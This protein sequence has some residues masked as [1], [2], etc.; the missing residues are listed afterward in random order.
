[1]PPLNR[2]EPPASLLM[3]NPLRVLVTR[4]YPPDLTSKLASEFQVIA[5]P[6]E[7]QSFNYEDV[8][9]QA[10]GLS[11][12]INQGELPID[13]PLIGAAPQ[14]RIVANTSIGVN[15]LALAPMRL[16]A[17]W[18]TNTPDAFVD[19]TADCTLGLMLMVARR[20]GEGER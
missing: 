10:A 1:M 5:P 11:A 2:D 14:L 9:R 20:M 8:L 3:K 15:N 19:A 17:I 7:H 12:I 16:R 4:A 13:A 6:D 18:G